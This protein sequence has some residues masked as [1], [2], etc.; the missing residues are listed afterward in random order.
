MTKLTI[1]PP[2]PEPKKETARYKSRN[3]QEQLMAFLNANNR[4]GFQED[5]A[6]VSIE[7]SDFENVNSTYGIADVIFRVADLEYVTLDMLKYYAKKIKKLS[8]KKNKAFAIPHQVSQTM[9]AV[10]LG[11]TSLSDV[12]RSQVT[13]PDKKELVVLNKRTKGQFKT[14]F[15]P[16]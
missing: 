4:N 13:L 12:I 6:T 7:A 8:V 3:M 16:D 9:V 10:V 2:G 15:F 1:L 11:Y 5:A 14:E